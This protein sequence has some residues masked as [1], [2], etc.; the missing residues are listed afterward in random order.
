MYY[1]E[2]STKKFITELEGY[3]YYLFVNCS[4]KTQYQYENYKFGFYCSTSYKNSIDSDIIRVTLNSRRISN[5]ITIYPFGK[6]F[7][8][9]KS[10][11]KLVDYYEVEIVFFKNKTDMLKFKLKEEGIE[12]IKVKEY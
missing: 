4:N 8:N 5:N 7:F 3:P 1:I 11:K 10:I 12:I 6:I 2:K 9:T